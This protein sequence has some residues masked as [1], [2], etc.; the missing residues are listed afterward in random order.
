MFR[1]I[2]SEDIKKGELGFVLY[3]VAGDK[4]M[5][6]DK[7]LKEEVLKLIKQLGLWPREVLE[8]ERLVSAFVSLL[9]FKLRANIPTSDVRRVF[10]DLYEEA[11]KGR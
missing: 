8:D 11:L 10:F 1:V 7:T 6:T 9:D 2:A 4:I 3:V 5:I